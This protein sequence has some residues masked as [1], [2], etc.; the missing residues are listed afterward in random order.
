MPQVATETGWDKEQ[1]LGELCSQKAGLHP[2]AYKDDPDVEL[3]TFT[4]Q[5]FSENE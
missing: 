1:F 3:L 2:S 4:A 5:V